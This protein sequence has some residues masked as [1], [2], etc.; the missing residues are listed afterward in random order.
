[1]GI[2]I[3]NMGIYTNALF[4][5]TQQRVLAVLFGRPD[6]SFYANEIIALAESGSGAVQREISRLEKAGLVTVSAIG[7]QKHYQA[8]PDAPIFQELCAI[9]TKTF[10]VADILRDAL[11][12]LWDDIDLAFVYGSIAK[13]TEHAGSDID[14]MVV[15]SPSITNNKLLRILRPIGEKL[16]REINPNLYTRDEFQQRIDDE[17]SFMVSVLTKNK[18]FIKGSEHDIPGNGELRE[19]SR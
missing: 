3:P 8:N 14:L 9:V 17:N 16:G 15:G 1:M 19:I 6:R 12:P 7:N 18:I 10:G 13:R 4:T 2:I 11:D 5:K